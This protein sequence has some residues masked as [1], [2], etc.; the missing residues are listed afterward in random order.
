[1]LTGYLLPR[2]LLELPRRPSFGMEM[3]LCLRVQ[4]GGVDCPDVE[5]L[6]H[7][8]QNLHCLLELWNLCN[9]GSGLPIGLLSIGLQVLIVEHHRTA[10]S[11]MMLHECRLRLGPRFL[12]WSFRH[13][14]V[15]AASFV[16]FGCEQGLGFS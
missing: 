10:V 15:P 3:C 16:S 14:E 4:F 6:P 9:Y 12:S 11:P 8:H 2:S 5:L 1:M 13:D 7:P